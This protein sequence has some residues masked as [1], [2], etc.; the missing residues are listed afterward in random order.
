MRRTFG[1]LRSLCTSSSFEIIQNTGKDI[2]Q[3]K[4]PWIISKG[5]SKAIQVIATARENK[6][7]ID[8]LLSIAPLCNCF[9]DNMFIEENIVFEGRKHLRCTIKNENWQSGVA[10]LIFLIAKDTGE[11][12]VAIRTRHGEQVKAAR[13]FLTEMG[14][15]DSRAAFSY[16]NVNRLYLGIRGFL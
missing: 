1:M 13:E 5:K 4:I 12:T 2:L 16:E 6:K 11:L 9:H 14:Y 15:I 10:C 7:R 8:S 3:H